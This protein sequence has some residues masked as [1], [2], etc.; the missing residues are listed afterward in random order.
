MVINMDN[1]ENLK[2][3]KENQ[4]KVNNEILQAVMQFCVNEK[5]AKALVSAMIRGEIPNVGVK[6]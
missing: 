1:I 2:L 5:S 4:R 3:I 6:Y